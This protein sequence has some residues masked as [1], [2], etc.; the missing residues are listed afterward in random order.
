MLQAPG[1][2]QDSAASGNFHVRNEHANVQIRINGIMLPDGV[3]GFGTFLDSALI[4]NISLITGALPAQYGLRTSGVLDITT[5]TDAF[6]NTGTAGIYGGSRGTLTPSFAIRRHRRADPILLHR[7]LVRKQYRPGESD[8]GL[9]RD[10]RPYR[11]GERLRL[12]LDDH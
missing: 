5:R 10:P 8:G 11:A 2:S 9:E 4:G 3:S 12:R 1:I 6:N 7:T